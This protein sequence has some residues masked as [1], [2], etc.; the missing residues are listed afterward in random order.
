MLCCSDEKWIQIDI[1]TNYEVSS[2]GRIKNKK[3]L[4]LKQR[5]HNDG[6]MGISLHKKNYLVHRLVALAFIKNLQNKKQVNHIDHC[7]SNNH[8]TNLQ[9]STRSDNIKHSHTKISRKQPK[10][11]SV[12]ELVH[13]DFKILN[14]YESVSK[15]SVIL[16]ITKST[17]RYRIHNNVIIGGKIWVYQYM[18]Y[19]LPTDIKSIPGLEDYVITKSGNVFVKRTK[20]PLSVNVVNGYKSVYI[21]GKIYKVH[22]LVALTW[23]GDPPNSSN[24]VNHIDQNKFNNHVDNLEYCTYQHNSAHT[25]GRAIVTIDANNTVVN[26]YNSIS[27]CSKKLN[28]SQRKIIQYCSNPNMTFNGLYLQFQTERS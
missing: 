2:C 5:K 25:S 6:Y 24:V 10:C 21:K 23:I 4:I 18:L 16:G 13:N 1:C 9:W 19:D 11:H 28:L 3:G 7:R 27:L 22:V 15:A 14:I 8:V 20:R 26:V 12:Y 17:L